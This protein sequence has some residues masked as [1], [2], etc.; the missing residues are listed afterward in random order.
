[1][2]TKQ[3]NQ[4]GNVMTGCVG[5]MHNT[6]R[7]GMN[8]SFLPDS[9]EIPSG[10]GNQVWSSYLKYEGNWN[11]FDISMRNKK[12]ERERKHLLGKERLC[13][14]FKR[15]EVDLITFFREGDPLKALL[16]TL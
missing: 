9:S 3:K 11:A 10:S 1:M 7:L 15:V 6:K 12:R 4:L 14:L 5:K 2:T 13:S 16:Q 8:P